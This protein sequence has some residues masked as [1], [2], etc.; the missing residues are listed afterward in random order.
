MEIEGQQRSISDTQSG[1]RSSVFAI[2]GV[3]NS[4][5]DTY[6]QTGVVPHIERQFLMNR[7]SGSFPYEL[8]ERLG[9]ELLIEEYAP[10]IEHGRGT[11]IEIAQ[12]ERGR[13]TKE[14]ALAMG[15][16]AMA[17]R[18]VNNYKAMLLTHE[19]GKMDSYGMLYFNANENPYNMHHGYAHDRRMERLL[20]MQFINDKQLRLGD[21]YWT[22]ATYLVASQHDATQ[23]MN[24]YRNQTEERTGERVLDEKQGHSIEAGIIPLILYKRL[25]KELHI[26]ESEAW[27]IA[28][29][30][31]F[32][33]AGHDEPEKYQKAIRALEPAQINESILELYERYRSG[34]V[35]RTTISPN[36][37]IGLMRIEK[38]AR[39]KQ[40]KESAY[41]E[42]STF[43]FPPDFELNHFGEIVEFMGMTD[44]ILPDLTI[45]RRD[46]LIRKAEA[47]LWADNSEFSAP[48]GEAFAR[49]LETAY[50]VGRPL[51]LSDSENFR[52]YVNSLRA[53]NNQEPFVEDASIVDHMFYDALMGPGNLKG[54]L[55]K[56]DSDLRRIVWELLH[57][58][59]Y[60]NAFR[61][62]YNKETAFLGA[63]NCRKMLSELMQGKIDSFDRMILGNMAS[64]GEKVMTRAGFSSKGI[65]ALRS[66][67]RKDGIFIKAVEK[68]LSRKHGVLA[69]KFSHIV[70]HEMEMR[71]AILDNW[72]NKPLNAGIMEEVTVVNPL[73]QSFKT[74]QKVEVYPD[75]QLLIFY[76]LMDKVINYLALQYGDHFGPVS[77]QEIARYEKMIEDGIASTM[78][79]YGTYYSI[80]SPDA[81][82]YIL[83]P[84]KNALKQIH[85]FAA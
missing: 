42:D 67:T 25:A 30:A 40:G 62:N 8:L 45:S 18:V 57:L 53:R 49:K 38:M 41:R 3:T 82:K 5:I 39:N 46:D 12:D 14:D 51:M 15:W 61:R 71:H 47:F 17:R 83:P 55:N 27:E 20:D 69:D 28:A 76:Q 1:S 52:T 80:S 66:I 2:D 9:T 19:D 68:I 75:S 70:N 48:A 65:N 26:S 84:H 63:L 78:Q 59:D 35:D 44:P 74:S 54:D 60:Q 79:P 56:F 11:W 43:G 58:D 10:K 16:V 77:S 22:I 7:E 85:S 24:T 72:S 31:L 34:T 36:Q 81:M 23:K 64:L 32:M 33:S 13:F 21:G 6:N 50:S 29:G 37:W 4:V 73:D